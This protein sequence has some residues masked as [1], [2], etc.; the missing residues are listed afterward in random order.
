MLVVV[1]QVRA[2]CGAGV[3]IERLRHVVDA[4]RASPHARGERLVV[5]VSGCWIQRGSLDRALRRNTVALIIDL[6]VIAEETQRR[7]SG[8]GLAVEVVEATRRRRVF[9]EVRRWTT[10]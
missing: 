2:V 6:D 4:L 3:P 7:L 10:R 1:E 5:D 9:D 8:A